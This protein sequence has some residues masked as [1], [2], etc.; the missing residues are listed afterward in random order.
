MLL[1]VYDCSSQHIVIHCRIQ[2][3]CCLLCDQLYN[4]VCI[5]QCVA[6]RLSYP[7]FYPQT[8]CTLIWPNQSCAHFARQLRSRS[9]G[10][11]AA[12]KKCNR[13]VPDEY[14]SDRDAWIMLTH[15]NPKTLKS[16]LSRTMNYLLCTF[17]CLSIDLPIFQTIHASICRYIT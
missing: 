13:G 15:K 9:S 10:E 12:P 6:D 14:R 3:M 17:A 5:Q 7:K 1:L 11:M 16:I 8:Y 2:K 4:N